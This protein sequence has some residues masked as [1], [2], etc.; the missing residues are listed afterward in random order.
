MS[1]FLSGAKCPA[2]GVSGVLD[3]EAEE[4]AHDEQVIDVVVTCVECQVVFNSFI[5]VNEMEQLP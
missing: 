5:N 4:S 3:M 1:I 2:C